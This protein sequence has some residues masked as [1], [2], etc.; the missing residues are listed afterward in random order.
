MMIS[1]WFRKT[2]DKTP[3]T[4]LV[5]TLKTLGIDSFCYSLDVCSPKPHAEF[6]SSVGGGA[7]MGGVWVTGADSLKID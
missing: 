6:D 4:F 3:H 7:L 5:K 1:N 2:F